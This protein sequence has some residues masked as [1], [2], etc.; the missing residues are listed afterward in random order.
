MLLV[1]V[2]I[3]VS[4]QCSFMLA[5]DTTHTVIMQKCML[6]RVTLFCT[7]LRVHAVPEDLSIY[8]E[9]N[10]NGMEDTSVRVVTQMPMARYV[11]DDMDAAQDDTPS[12]MEP[13]DISNRTVGIILFWVVPLLSLVCMLIY[14]MEMVTI[15]VYHNHG[16]P[17]EWI[18]NKGEPESRL[19]II[20]NGLGR[21]R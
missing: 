3:W 13:A 19:R 5:A 12:I 15:R 21:D 11:I 6:I 20:T 18:L 9:F 10:I 7:Q 8:N 16:L 2:L 1:A 14:I 17:E 4:W